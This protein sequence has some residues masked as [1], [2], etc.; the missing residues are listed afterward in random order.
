MPPYCVVLIDWFI[1]IDCSSG[2][3]NSWRVS[4][5]AS[6][7]TFVRCVA[8][9]ASKGSVSPWSRTKEI[10][11][12]TVMPSWQYEWLLSVLCNVPLSQ[13]WAADTL[14]GL[15]NSL[16][17]HFVLFY[18][19]TF[20]SPSLV[21]SLT[22]LQSSMITSAMVPEVWCLIASPDDGFRS[23]GWFQP[24]SRFNSI[25]QTQYTVQN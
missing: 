7:T 5:R 9:I 2:D 15:S 16:S 25:A 21:Q 20:A 14:L 24:T 3:I 17:S 10:R 23:L 19:S 12:T 22:A 1:F 18:L 8:S 6:K 4:L 11:N 13:L